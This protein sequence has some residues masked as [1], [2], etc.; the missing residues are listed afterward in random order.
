MWCLSWL[1]FSVISLMGKALGWLLYHLAG[2]R[3]RVGMI[4]L[5]L[6]LPELTESERQQLLRQHF[7]H[8]AT[9]L[10]EY[11]YCWYASPERLRRMVRLE[12]EEHLRAVAGRPVI[13]FAAHFVGLELAGI[14]LSA[15]LPMVTIYSKQKNRDLDAIIVEKRG[16]FPQSELASRQDGVR[17]LVKAMKRGKAAY[18]LPDQDFGPD[19]S[20]FVPFFG[21]EAATVPALPRLARLAGAAVVPCM[22]RRENGGYVLRC[23]PAWEDYPG[24]TVQ[25][26]TRRMNAFIEDRIRE[27][28]AQYFWLHKR[29]KT[30]PE[31]QARY[32]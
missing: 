24:E 4:N 1:P 27:A 10:L 16:R 29:F 12:G 28:P 32:Y 23:Y 31:G 13:L 17:P 19:D 5:G 21:V 26:D 25:T 7:Q 22:V 30:R 8:M 6:C 18:Y 14:R 15:D 11:G 3:R 20:I 9:M 2:E